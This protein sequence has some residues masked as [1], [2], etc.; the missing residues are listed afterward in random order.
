MTL[1][2]HYTPDEIADKLHVS[3][4]TVLRECRA[5]RL[6]SF[7]VP[8][9]RSRRIPESAITEWLHAGAEGSSV[10]APVISIEGRR[11]GVDSDAATG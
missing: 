10:E 8:G 2:Q 4:S 7:V 3:P 5:G 1:E 9:G 6:R 11:H